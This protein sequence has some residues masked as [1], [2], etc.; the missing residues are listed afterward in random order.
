MIIFSNDR[1]VPTD[2]NMMVIRS[3]DNIG[4]IYVHRSLLEQAVIIQDL[5]EDDLPRLIKDVT[6]SEESRGDVD[7]FFENAPVPINY[8]APFLLLV[9]SE[10]E[11]M[12]DMYGALHVMSGQINFRRMLK[13]PFDMRSNPSF[14]LSINEEYQLAW[15][16][17]FLNTMPYDPDMLSR[18]V[19]AEPL[20]MNGTANDP[21]EDPYEGVDP[22]C[23]GDDGK[24]YASPLEAALFGFNPDAIEVDPDELEAEMGD[25]G[26]DSDKEEEEQEPE[27]EPEPESEPE[28]EKPKTGIDAL[29]GGML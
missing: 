28:P 12:N 13:I 21:E 22:E 27:P 4:Y 26:E 20:P 17:F 6:G 16:R 9:K 7:F 8:L 23:I 2:V 18:S 11:N 29:L 10:L 19:S 5:Y 25:I 1:L 24:V 14:S 3:R 15:D